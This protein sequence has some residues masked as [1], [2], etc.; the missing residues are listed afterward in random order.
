MWILWWKQAT[1]VN[2]IQSA[3]C[4]DMCL[5]VDWCM[6]DFIR[7][8]AHTVLS[9]VQRLCNLCSNLKMFDVVVVVVVVGR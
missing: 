3:I 1:K 4:A 5:E 2:K 6:E 9:Q 8:I 7:I